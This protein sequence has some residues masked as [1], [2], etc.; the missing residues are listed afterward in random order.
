M[1][2]KNKKKRKKEDK[3]LKRLRNGAAGVVTSELM[4]SIVSRVV[5]D[6]IESYLSDKRNLKKVMKSI[7]RM[8]SRRGSSAR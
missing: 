8:G 4:V 1:P 3:A 7:R 6:V 5:T 2:K